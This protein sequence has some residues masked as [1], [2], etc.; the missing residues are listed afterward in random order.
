ME[1]LTVS[2]VSLLFGNSLTKSNLK[3]ISSS[4]VVSSDSWKS[5]YLEKEV[6]GVVS[7]CFRA[8]FN[9]VLLHCP[10]RLLS[11]QHILPFF[12]RFR[13]RTQV[14]GQPK[15][16]PFSAAI[17]QIS[18]LL[19][20][21][22]RRNSGELRAQPRVLPSAGLKSLLSAGPVPAFSWKP[23]AS[24]QPSALFRGGD[25]CPGQN[26]AGSRSR[27]AGP[28]R[29]PHSP[30]GRHPRPARHPQLLLHLLPAG[31]QV[32]NQEVD[33]P[34]VVEQLPEEGQVPRL[35]HALLLQRF[36]QLVRAPSGF[37]P[38]PGDVVPAEELE[39]LQLGV[40]QLVAD[41]QQQRQ[42]HGRAA[43]AQHG[44]RSPPPR[45]AGPGPGRRFPL[46]W[47]F[48]RETARP[49]VGS[50]ACWGMSAHISGCSGARSWA[51][52]TC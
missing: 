42:L 36:E 37:Q 51:N 34:D 27:S 47:T 18:V 52:R 10:F 25:G 32:G 29:R 33:P 44:G 24:S 16:K 39:R 9:S 31:A 12:F 19:Q 8:Q 22:P 7:S 41:R 48:R 45:E 35:Q 14:P 38:P 46:D 2:R 11:P 43:A 40:A 23:P 17:K 30:E 1:I 50:G 21:K 4:S 20:W 28:A 15:V 6:E 49:P 5:R 13:W 26:E 3:D